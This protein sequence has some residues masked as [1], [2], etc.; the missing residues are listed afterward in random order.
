MAPLDDKVRRIGLGQR[1]IG[2]RNQDLI[3]V[4]AAIGI[5][6]DHGVAGGSALVVEEAQISAGEGI[7]AV[8]SGKTA[9]QIVD[10]E[11]VAGRTLGEIGD[12]VQARAGIGFR[13]EIEDVAA[14]AAGEDV[15]IR[16]ADQRV[17]AEPAQE[18]VVAVAAIEL[19]VAGTAIRAG[20]KRRAASK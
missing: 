12:P 13:I 2:Q 16:T 7:A 15:V 3:V 6:P 10:V 20:R 17:V 8:V 11:H 19:V 9:Q 14:G 18:R 5:E 4:T 1:H